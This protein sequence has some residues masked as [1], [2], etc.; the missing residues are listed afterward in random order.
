[1]MMNFY[2]MLRNFIKMLISNQPEYLNLNSGSIT[3]LPNTNIP[4]YGYKS[5]KC[6]GSN[7]EV[8]G[9]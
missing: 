8:T 9:K 1:M 6:Y 5:L 7:W 3:S 4:I 2:H